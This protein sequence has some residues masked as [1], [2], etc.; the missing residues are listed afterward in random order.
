MDTPV[1]PKRVF[2]LIQ[3]DGD[4]YWRLDFQGDEGLIGIGPVLSRAEAEKDANE[5]LGE[6]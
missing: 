2:R 4:W 1:A 3:L 6:S 5:T